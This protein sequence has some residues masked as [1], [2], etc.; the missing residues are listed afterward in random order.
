MQTLERHCS[1]YL[2][3]TITKEVCVLNLEYKTSGLDTKQVSD[4]FRYVTKK[5]KMKWYTKI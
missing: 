2:K 4:A 1:M 5:R 3:C